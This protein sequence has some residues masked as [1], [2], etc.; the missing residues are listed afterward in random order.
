MYNAQTDPPNMVC[1]VNRDTDTIITAQCRLLAIQRPCDRKWKED[2]ENNKEQVHG[3]TSDTLFF[4][5]TLAEG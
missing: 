4:Y 5:V 2:E 3:F 1:R